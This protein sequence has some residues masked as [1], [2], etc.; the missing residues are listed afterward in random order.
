MEHFKALYE[1]VFFFPKKHEKFTLDLYEK[2]EKNPL[3]TLPQINRQ[4][5]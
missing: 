3:G 2:W 1:N 4:N 5:L